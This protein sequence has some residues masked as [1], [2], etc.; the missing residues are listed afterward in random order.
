MGNGRDPAKHPDY[1]FRTRRGLVA[2]W[3]DF[4]SR[5]RSAIRD[6]CAMCARAA[7]ALLP[8]RRR[9]ICSATLGPTALIMPARSAERI[10]DPTILSSLD[11]LASADLHRVRNDRVIQIPVVVPRHAVRLPATILVRGAHP[12]LVS[13]R[14][15]VPVELPSYPGRLD[16]R[17]Q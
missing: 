6:L 11:L 12:D 2:L 3:A 17:R 15:G 10:T 16:V 9:S 1:G 13:A 14:R 5:N 8:P 7:I 4:I